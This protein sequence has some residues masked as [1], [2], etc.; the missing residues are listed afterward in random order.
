MGDH[1]AFNSEIFTCGK[2][3]Y[4]II[5]TNFIETFIPNC[6]FKNVFPS[7]FGIEIS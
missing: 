2:I 4:S 5:I 7:Y 1:C 3:Y 6:W